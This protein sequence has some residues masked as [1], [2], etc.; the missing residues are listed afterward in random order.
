[1]TEFDTLMKNY[2]EACAVRD[3]LDQQHERYSEDIR[4]LHAL[5]ESLY[6]RQG[7]A[8]NSASLAGKRLLSHVAKR[9]L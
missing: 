3:D 7:D 5:R 4:K 8:A 6:G 9:V 1:M 2:Q